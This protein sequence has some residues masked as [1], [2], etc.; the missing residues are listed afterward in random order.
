MTHRLPSL[1]FA[2][3]L[4]MVVGVS[5]R[6]DEGPT[7]PTVQSPESSASP[8]LA[9]VANSWTAKAP[10]PTGRSSLGGAVV[11][12][13]LGQPIFYAIG[14]ENGVQRLA[15][16]EAYNAAT[17]SWR[18]RASLPDSLWALNGVGVIGGKLYVAGGL[19]S[20]P[21]E[22]PSGEGTEFSKALYVYNPGN[23]TWSRKADL[24]HGTTGGVTGV[25]NGKLYLLTGS[26][27]QHQ[28]ATDPIRK[29]W[30]YD[31]GTNR[32][33]TSLP[34]CPEP[35]YLGAGGVIAGKFYVA[36][37][38]GESIQNLHLHVFD[39]A[40]NKWTAKAS[41]PVYKTSAAGAVLGGKLYLMGGFEPNRNW[42]NTVRVYNPTTNTWTTKAPMLTARYGLAAGRLTINGRSYILA[43]GG[44]GGINASRANERYTP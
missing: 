39:P 44:H 32:W 2:L 3:L 23:N 28:C 17:N 31:P 40:T 13:S 41:L 24:P 9:V 20:N 10:M 8:S 36:G 27:P 15:K 1:A 12:N 43:V 29:L 30:R 38:Y 16:V 5:C 18:T 11:N 35:H 26:C 14:G 34:P 19:N 42:V 25:I 7:L 22:D 21:G 4:A 37:G 6:P 33:N